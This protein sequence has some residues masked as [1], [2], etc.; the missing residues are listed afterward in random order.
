MTEYCS[1]YNSNSQ[2]DPQTFSRMPDESIGFIFLNIS[3]SG[4]SSK[5]FIALCSLNIQKHLSP[6]TVY[7]HD[8]NRPSCLQIGFLFLTQLKHKAQPW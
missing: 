5:L 8:H 3:F 2:R 1:E 7:I 4:C 6:L